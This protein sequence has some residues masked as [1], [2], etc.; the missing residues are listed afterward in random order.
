MDA[1][2]K[3]MMSRVPANVPQRERWRSL[4]RWLRMICR[5]PRHL[6]PQGLCP[7]RRSSRPAQAGRVPH[8]WA[9][10]LLLALNELVKCALT[11]CRRVHPHGN[12]SRT[13]ETPHPQF[14]HISLEMRG[15]GH[16][17][18][19]KDM[20]KNLEETKYRLS[21]LAEWYCASYLGM[22]SV[23]LHNC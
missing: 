23:G 21:I 10:G 5:G 14:P 7:L 2:I 6:L 4:L 3:Q 20:I 22:V 8:E 15:G 19:G 9:L 11:V 13:R 17:A 12:H 1:T 16:E 18:V